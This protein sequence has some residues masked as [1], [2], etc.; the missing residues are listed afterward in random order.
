MYG[1]VN[2]NINLFLVWKYWRRSQVMLA[3]YYPNFTKFNQ[4]ES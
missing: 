4:M 3:E 2:M 1:E